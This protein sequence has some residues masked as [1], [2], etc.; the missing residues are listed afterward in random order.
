MPG[1]A[2]VATRLLSLLWP[3]GA[4]ALKLRLA[5]AG[6]LVLGAKLLGVAAPLLYKEIVDNLS[7]PALAAVPVAL[8]VAYALAHA[9]VRGVEAL[10]QL[11]F[12]RVAQRAVRL[13]A[14]ELYRHL[15]GLSL[16]FHLERRTGGVARAIE[17]GT[18]AIETLI[19]LLLFTLV[20][21]VLELA[22][23]A[24]ILWG[25]YSA[26]FALATLATVLCYAALTL[27]ATGRQVRLRREMNERDV[28]ASVRAV[29]ALLNYETVKYFTAEEH[30]A[31]RFDSAKR[32][33]EDA[34]VR[35]EAAETWLALGQ[36]A[37]VAAGL[38]AVMAMA[39]RSVDAGTMTVG[40]F[41]AVV[42][43]LLQ[44]YAPLG[45]A[46]IVYSSA[47]QSLA[48]FEL[49]DRLLA[50]PREIEDR[51][52]APALAVRRGHVEFDGVSFAYDRRRPVLDGVSFEIRPGATVALVGASGGGKST[53]ARLLFRFYDP[54]AGAIRIDGQDLREVTQQS[55]RGA[56]GVVPQDTVLFD[57]SLYYN[58]AY[59]RAGA[60]RSEVEEAARAARLH[61]FIETLPDGYGTRVGERGLMLSGG[62]R[63]RVA[64][65]RVILK[66]PAILLFD[67][68]TSA[69]DS[70]T[71]REIQ[72]SLAALAAG[73]STLVIAHRLSTIVDADQILVLEGGRIVERGG[74]R[75]L[76]GSGGGYAA[77]WHRQQRAARRPL[78]PG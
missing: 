67:E 53:L 72:A 47:R 78:E 5:A 13:T 2:D 65:A 34:S 61:D 59:G 32:E 51:P 52:G 4:P 55:L 10:R 17:R 70:G 69:L 7:A 57:D 43:Y 50:E 30:E 76:V 19:E 11:L 77:M 36:G 63:Q 56:I 42:A 64:I 35:R 48:D 24:A 16:R 22:L 74:H 23:V 26:G 38:V 29:D 6:L 58:I 12:V 68:A 33:V 41:V 40:D 45:T 28:A 62:E 20:P 8:V 9:G 14:L 25:F 44:L 71:E 39:A 66:R 31:A 27:A 46:G 3:R 15:L 49:V 73:R 1:A 21:T 54:I 60:S 37:I 75:E 18:A